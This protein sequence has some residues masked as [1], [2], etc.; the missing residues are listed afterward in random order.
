MTEAAVYS[1]IA[2]W[3]ADTFY[4]VFI[5]VL[6]VNLTQRRHQSKAEKKRFATLYLGLAVF[7]FF[8]LAQLIVRFGGSDWMLIPSVLLIVATVYV[9]RE[10][11]FPFR[12]YSPVDG[13]RLTFQE[14]LYDDNHGD[15]PSET[16][17]DAE[18]DG[19]E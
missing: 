8:I 3:V 2:V 18:D 15:A 4:W 5:A 16:S 6:V 7:V 1:P 14:I 12:L 19:G 17:D 13:R 10:H 9:L 11:T